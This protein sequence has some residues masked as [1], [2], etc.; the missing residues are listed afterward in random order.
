[1][2]KLSQSAVSAG[3]GQDTRMSAVSEKLHG[4]EESLELITLLLVTV[5]DEDARWLSGILDRRAWRISAARTC[6]DAVLQLASLTPSVVLCERDLPDGNW[7]RV[8]A[9][10]KNRDR[11]P[12]MLV[13]S[14]HADEHLWAEVLNLGGYDVLQKPFDAAEVSRVLA[15]ARRFWLSR[16]DFHVPGQRERYPRIRQ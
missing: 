16:Q 6:A 4:Q 14:C 2:G 15:M 3:K 5:S 12:L 1:V 7:K 13:T 9:E 8:F 10:A 11:E